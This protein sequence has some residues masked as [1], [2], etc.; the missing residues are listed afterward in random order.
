MDLVWCLGASLLRCWKC[1]DDGSGISVRW[2]WGIQNDISTLSYST[3]Y[4]FFFADR[5]EN[6]HLGNM[7][8]YRVT[9]EVPL[10]YA[11]DGITH[12]Q[13]DD[14]DDGDEDG[15][16]RRSWIPLHRPSFRRPSKMSVV[17]HMDED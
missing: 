8:Q 11:F 14:Y 12:D 13:D 10:P 9:R 7:D 6:E 1:S 16:S 3:H 15:R 17:S 5:L 2:N 4:H